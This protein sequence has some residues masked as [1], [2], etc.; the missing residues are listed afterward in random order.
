LKITL[1]NIKYDEYSNKKTLKELDGKADLDKDVLYYEDVKVD[2]DGI[3]LREVGESATPHNLYPGDEKCYEKFVHD[4][5]VPNPDLSIDDVVKYN[6][7][8]HIPFKPP[9]NGSCSTIY[10][11][12][13]D[14]KKLNISGRN[15]LNWNQLRKVNGVHGFAIEDRTKNADYVT[16]NVNYWIDIPNYIGFLQITD[17]NED[18]LIDEDKNLS[19]TMID[20]R[21]ISLKAPVINLGNASGFD[22]YYLLYNVKDRSI[23]I[24]IL[25]GDRLPGDVEYIEPSFVLYRGRIREDLLTQEDIAAEDDSGNQ[26]AREKALFRKL[27]GSFESSLRFRIMF[28]DTFKRF[29]YPADYDTRELYNESTNPDCK[30]ALAPQ[31]IDQLTDYLYKE[32][33]DANEHLATV[34]DISSG[35]MV[36]DVY[37]SDNEY[38]EE[39]NHKVN[40]FKGKSKYVDNSYVIRNNNVYPDVVGGVFG[41]LKYA[42]LINKKYFEDSEEGF[43]NEFAN[44]CIE[45]RKGSLYCMVLYTKRIIVEDD[46]GNARNDNTKR[47]T[48]FVFSIDEDFPA[49][50]MYISKD[51]N[52]DIL[53]CEDITKE[54]LDYHNNSNS[55][56]MIMSVDLTLLAQNNRVIDL[57]ELKCKAIPA[58]EKDGKNIPGSKVQIGYD[59]NTFDYKARFIFNLNLRRIDARVF[60]DG[61][62][63]ERFNDNGIFVFDKQIYDQLVP[64][65]ENGKRDFNQTQTLFKKYKP[66][67]DDKFIIMNLNENFIELL[68]SQMFIDKFNTFYSSL[69]NRVDQI[70]PINNGESTLY[71]YDSNGS[72]IYTV[73]ND[74]GF[75]VP[76]NF[77]NDSMDVDEDS[78]GL[79]EQ[80]DKPNSQVGNNRNVNK[81]KVVVKR[82][83]DLKNFNVE[84]VKEKLRDGS[85]NYEQFINILHSYLDGDLDDDL[86]FHKVDSYSTGEDNN[87]DGI[88]DIIELYVDTKETDLKS[89]SFIFNKKESLFSGVKTDNGIIYTEGNIVGIKP[90]L[91][92][93]EENVDNVKV[94]G[95]LS[96]KVVPIEFDLDKD[97]SNYQD[98]EPKWENE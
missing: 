63:H 18:I 50:I 5:T 78:V 38:N 2:C 51:P 84:Y 49:E 11:S 8:Y 96:K 93:S 90:S 82:I 69:D 58:Y 89:S 25:G 53:Y 36:D 52:V 92:D 4:L 98:D 21:A 56:D 91:V 42:P 65:L 19:N 55:D 85:F 33:V 39:E 20:F 95:V 35:Q 81:E 3:Q 15:I 73:Q 60:E 97:V 9:R 44:D 32:K 29:L 59:S 30:M 77:L 22:C 40:R 88:D 43:K 6:Y 68:G 83:I 24:K 45:L 67:V 28:F 16:N 66:D 17:Q 76:L 87:D 1:D 10:R 12:N 41:D 72:I 14:A 26:S 57:S 70:I 61:E 47:F 27:V 71:E 94:F 31:F 54:A 46:E 13:I 37:E 34:V 74:E 62:E 80:L 23:Y 79:E 48:V 86:E 64:E 75:N 7:L